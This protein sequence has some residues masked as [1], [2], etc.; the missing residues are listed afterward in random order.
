M[1]RKKARYDGVVKEVAAYY[2]LPESL[3][4]AVITAESAYNPN[5][6]SSA[7]ARGLMQLMPG[8]AR[9]F[10]V[11][12]AYNPSENIR[13]GAR[14]LKTLMGM[15]NS[16]LNLVLAAY[17]AGEGAVLKHGR[18]IPPYDETRRYVRKVRAYYEQYSGES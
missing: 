3:L 5:A 2:N 7:G 10:G 18:R 12:N 15:F 11:T 14:Y 6:V 4:H 1:T 8:T 17:N 13:G 16:D 9:R